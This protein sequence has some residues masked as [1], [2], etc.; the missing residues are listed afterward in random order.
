[1]EIIG[2]FGSSLPFIR[3][4]PSQGALEEE[5]WGKEIVEWEGL[6]CC[7]HW[8]GGEALTDSIGI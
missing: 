3:S 1:M 7:G 4:K 5:G 2:E 8:Q 6:S